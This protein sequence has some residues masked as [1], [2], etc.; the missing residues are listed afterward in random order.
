MCTR[1]PMNSARRFTFLMI[2]SSIRSSERKSKKHATDHFCCERFLPF[3]FCLC[4]IRVYQPRSWREMK[5]FRG[6]I[7]R[8]RGVCLV[9]THLKSHSPSSF[10]FVYRKERSIFRNQFLRPA[11]LS[12]AGGGRTTEKVCLTLPG[13]IF[14]SRD[15]LFLLCLHP[16]ILFSVSIR[17]LHDC[18]LPK[19]RSTTP[20]ITAG[21]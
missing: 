21:R 20:A 4:F 2:S 13:C 12:K 10:V 1:T 14:R 19:G 5:T 3:S 17:D 8:Q 16:V 6:R 18:L 15:F 9:S 7:K 11:L